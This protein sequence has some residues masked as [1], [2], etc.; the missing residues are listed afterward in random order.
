[1]R[2]NIYLLLT[3]ALFIA[4]LIANDEGQ[5]KQQETRSPNRF[6][7]PKK[8]TTFIVFMSADN[9]L[10]Y[11]A[12]HNIEQMKR[13]GSNEHLNIVIQ[14]N[15]PGVATPTRR[16]YIEKNG[17]K[18]VS[19]IIGEIP[20]K[21]NSGSPQTL[22]DCVRWASEDFPAENYILALWDHATGALEPGP[23]RTINTNELFFVNPESNKLELDRGGEG[24]FTVL[25]Q[26]LTRRNKRA[27]CFDDSYQSYISN[28][29]L[30]FALEEIHH[31]VLN[32]PLDGVGFDACLMGM[33]EIANLAKNHALFM[34]GSQE[35]EFGNGWNYELILRAFLNGPVEPREFFK[36]MV[37]AYDKEYRP[38]ANDFTQSAFDLALTQD[39]EQ[40]INDLAQLLIKLFTEQK[41]TNIKNI[42]KLC[43]S[44]Q[45]C[46]CFDEPS[47]IDLGHFY[48]N[49]L[50]YLTH[51][52]FNN[53]E[54]GA[55]LLEEISRLLHQGLEVINHLVIQNSVGNGLKNAHGISI[56]FPEY[57]IAS[58]Y[59]RSNFGS[60]N[61][62]RLFLEY[63]L[64]S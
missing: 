44:P 60:N 41:S 9:D 24:F 49:L 5:I 18:L 53:Q 43:K 58:S 35:I 42:I 27:I 28:K 15:S 57:R 48:K 7:Q 22:I 8:H 16:F 52:Q 62:W 6:T 55:L 23:Y 29:E 45:Y 25:N 50:K 1:M 59:L 19:P 14:I 46:T 34:V 33:I 38:I 32:K 36:H 39:L 51:A 10:H 56:Y 40:N 26:E 30:Q 61:D 11:F 2:K 63:Y 20:Q 54:Q 17:M 4:P 3:F 12:W 47:Y 31:K 37:R 64:S 21:Y 13:V